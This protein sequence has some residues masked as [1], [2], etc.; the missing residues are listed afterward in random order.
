[1]IHGSWLHHSAWK[2][3]Q[4]GNSCSVLCFS[5]QLQL[6]SQQLWVSTE[7]GSSHVDSQT[8][9]PASSSHPLSL[10]LST[11]EAVKEAQE[12]L[13]AAP[14]Q[15]SA[16]CHVE[17]SVEEDHRASVTDSLCLSAARY[18]SCPD[19]WSSYNSR[20]FKFFDTA[21]TWYNAEIHCYNLGGHL[22][23]VSDP[24]E[25]GFLQSLAQGN[26][27]TNVWLGGFRLQGRW[28]WI[29]GQGFYYTNWNSLSSSSSYDCMYSLNTYGWRNTGCTNSYRF[30]CSM[31]PFGC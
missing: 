20:C 1:M 15:F 8:V 10:F 2:K 11:E 5:L 23:S 31:N 4:K 18:N 7:A 16:A 21:M 14:G 26:G 9:T 6:S 29:D 12:E 25:Y 24:R 22:A 19:G 13:A 30:I 27:Q 17:T 3:G 28:I